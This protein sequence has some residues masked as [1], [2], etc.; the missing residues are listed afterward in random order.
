MFK[1]SISPACL[2]VSFTNDAKTEK[3]IEEHT[4]PRGQQTSHVDIRTTSLL[5]GAQLVQTG[6]F[7]MSAPLQLAYFDTILDK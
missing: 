1:I 7:V 6:R 2:L 4:L 3:R 5:T